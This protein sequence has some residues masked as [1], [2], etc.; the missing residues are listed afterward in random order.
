MATKVCRHCHEEFESIK[1]NQ[2]YCCTAHQKAE[3]MAIRNKKMREQKGFNPLLPS[4]FFESEEAR[5]Q[6]RGVFDWRNHPAYVK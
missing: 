1:S 4:T 5:R 6:E 3:N 2:I